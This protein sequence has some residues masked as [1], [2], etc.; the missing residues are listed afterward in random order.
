MTAAE[1]PLAS[2]LGILPR[3]SEETV[4]RLLLELG[5]RVVGAEEASLL[6]H[7]PRENALV[8]VMTIGRHESEQVLRGQKVPLGRGVTGLAAVTGEV[9]IG[10]PTYK[11]LDY[12]ERVNEKGEPEA[13][14]AAPMLKGDELIGVI[15]AVS[16]DRAKRFGQK[17][18]EV[19]MCCAMI[20]AV[21]V[22]QHQRLKAYENASPIPSGSPQS[23][24]ESD[25]TDLEI[26]STV[27]ALMR[28]PSAKRR[29]VAALLS[30]VQAIIRDA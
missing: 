5:M 14:I 13:V 2:T 7:E 22:E 1:S 27:S 17:D 19:M 25:A 8:F 15:T 11:D 29:Q 26:V 24:N 23:R 10:A 9:Q 28:C 20:A 4:L 16:F 30:A 6:V 3:T 18:G 12:A 21:V